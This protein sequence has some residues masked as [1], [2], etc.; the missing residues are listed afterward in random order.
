MNF[1]KLSY[2]ALAAA[3]A[4]VPMAGALI[5]P[6]SAAPI[7]ITAVDATS[8][9]NEYDSSAASEITLNFTLTNSLGI[10]DTITVQ[11][12]DTIDASTNTLGADLAECAV[13]TPTIDSATY[14][15]PVFST[16]AAT[17]S[18]PETEQAVYT[19]TSATAATP[20]ATSLCITFPAG[21]AQASYQ[22]VLTTSQG[23]AGLV[24]IHVNDDNDVLVTA[25][26]ALELA[27][28]IRLADDTA[29]TNICEIGVVDT[30][31]VPNHDTTVDTGAANPGGECAYGIAVNTNATGG[32]TTTIASNGAM[33]NGTDTITD[34]TTGA[35]FQALT[36][37]DDAFGI[38]SVVPT[39]TVSLDPDGLFD[40]AAILQGD[41]ALNQGTGG[42][43][44][45]TAATAL[46]S[47]GG[48]TDYVQGTD[49]TDLTI[50]I[51]GIKINGTTPAGIYAQTQTINTTAVF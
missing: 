35:D 37:A 38:V 39:N 34:V 9:T 26:V 7:T 21:A 45:P 41:F 36:A 12:S 16:I 25:E 46:V 27:Q 13:P 42:T 4:V 8:T 2:K 44:V 51:N 15:A 23:D 5:T 17:A 28:N 24:L 43:P 49:A 31:T 18:T 14:S 1:K 32:F 29:D 19:L 6:V 50:V 40:D 30:T 47:G 33:T 20:A 3:V 22:V 11:A 48:R 10:G